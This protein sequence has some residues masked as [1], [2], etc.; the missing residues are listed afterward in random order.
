MRWRLYDKLNH[1]WFDDDLYK[2]QDACLVV[3]NMYM[4]DA[5]VAG[6]ELQLV[7]EPVDPSESL[8]R[9]AATGGPQP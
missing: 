7:A 3:G 6:D 8:Q 2:T 1:Q 9:T 5:R 4:C